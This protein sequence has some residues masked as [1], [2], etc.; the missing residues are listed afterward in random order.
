MELKVKAEILSRRGSIFIRKPVYE[1][2]NIR[3]AVLA[4]LY[5]KKFGKPASLIVRTSDGY[6]VRCVADNQ[7]GYSKE[8]AKFNDLDVKVIDVYLAGDWQLLSSL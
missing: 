2:M 1:D 3:L 5:N 7:G 8:L 6:Y 4:L